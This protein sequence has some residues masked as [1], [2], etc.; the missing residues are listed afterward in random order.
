METAAVAVK[1]SSSSPSIPCTK[2]FNQVT[3]SIILFRHLTAQSFHLPLPRLYEQSKFT[4]ITPSIRPISA[5][6][7]LWPLCTVAAHFL[8]LADERKERTA[9]CVVCCRRGAVCKIKP[10]HL[11]RT[12]YTAALLP[13]HSLCYD[14]LSSRCRLSLCLYVCLQSGQGRI[15]AEPCILCFYGTANFYLAE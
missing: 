10:L 3:P 4:S 6:S 2:F 12:F 5:L 14:P 1:L 13:S 7:P 9:P 11:A 8:K 15:I